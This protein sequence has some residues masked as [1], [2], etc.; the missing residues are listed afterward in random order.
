MHRNLAG[1]WKW[2]A[3]GTAIVFTLFH[4]YTGGFGI[5]PDMQQRAIHVLFGFTLTLLLFSPFKPA[6]PETRVSIW[7]VLLIFLTIACCV[8]TY[9]KFEWFHLNIGESTT[10][11]LFLG[12]AIVILALE[13]GRRVV[14]WVFPIL[15]TVFLLYAFLGPYIPGIFRHPGF[16][17]V[18]VIQTLNQTTLGVWG[19]VT[20]I[21]ATLLAIFIIFSTF[22]LFT[23]GGQ[24]FIEIAL[25]VAG[26]Y[27]GG[28]ALVAVV[29]SGFFGTISG[30]A[31]ANVVGTG[32]FTIPLMKR[33]GYA[34]EFAGGVEATASSGG[35]IMPPI[36]GAGAFIMAELLGIPYIKVAFSAAIPACLFYLAVFC[37][38]RFEALRLNLPAVPAE[39]ILPWRQIFTWKR[40]AP[41]FFPVI[42]LVGLLA[43]G[44]TPTTA[45]FWACIMALILFLFSD[46]SLA[47]VKRR[48]KVIL[49]GFEQAGKSLV[50][51]VSLLVC[52]N[53][54]ISL[55]NLTGVG[56]KVSE[57]IIGL[58]GS[59]IFLSLVFGAIVAIILGM[60]MPTTGAYLIS[61]SVIGTALIKLG[62]I[63]LSAHL[64][65]FYFAVISAITPPVCVAVYAA[66]GIAQAD[67]LKI[68]RVAL[69]LGIVAYLVP[70]IF[71]YW[72]ALLMIGKPIEIIWATVSASIGAIFLG[73][74]MMGYLT[75][76][77]SIIK[78]ILLIPGAVLLVIPG[79]ETDVIGI[80]II[81]LVLFGRRLIPITLFQKRNVED[82]L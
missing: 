26:K 55:I 45:G 65:L 6:K 13:A 11:D 42:A 41:L 4:L 36:M 32:S 56:I 71:V 27:R 48:I 17:L 46:F 21:S 75:T 70:F 31:V 29:A 39:E 5:L 22:L 72:P 30:S 12:V 63:P 77:L 19:F 1:I 28:P 50:E 68:A 61:A 57:L 69:K 2:I 82:K 76:R 51:I 24:S 18:Y 38:V 20:G 67:W 78:R 53:I 59:S 49:T 73:A 16:D 58:A 43:R 34:P 64:F 79:W 14:G 9:L 25:R 62:L 47:N 10:L 60:G 54:M 23:G 52:A 81:A 7:D 15:T 66:S 8:N 35:Q 80:G 40:L 37:A 44:Y 74:A 3:Q 33:L